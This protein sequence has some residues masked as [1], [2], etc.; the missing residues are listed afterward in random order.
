VGVLT[1][2]TWVCV[3][4]VFLCAIERPELSSDE[5]RKIRARS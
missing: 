5:S 3:W 2:H 1:L 4:G